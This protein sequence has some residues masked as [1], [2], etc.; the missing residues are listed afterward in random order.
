MSNR[1]AGVR[2]SMTEHERKQRAT[3]PD[4]DFP[5]EEDEIEEDLDDEQT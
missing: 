3:Y 4:Y 1:F 5:I 2:E